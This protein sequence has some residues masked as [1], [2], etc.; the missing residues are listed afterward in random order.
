MAD[1][2]VTVRSNGNDDIEDFNWLPGNGN[3]TSM[4][5]TSYSGVNSANVLLE[6]LPKARQFADTTRKY[7]L[8]QRRSL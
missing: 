1:D 8:K 6:Q 7:V 2:D 5:R 3:F 4:W